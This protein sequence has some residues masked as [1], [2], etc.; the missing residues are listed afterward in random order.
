[1]FSLVGVITLACVV[2]LVVAGRWG[3]KF[4]EW[5]A[6]HEGVPRPGGVVVQLKHARTR[7]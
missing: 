7:E 4:W 1:V 3:R 5:R 6:R 2:V